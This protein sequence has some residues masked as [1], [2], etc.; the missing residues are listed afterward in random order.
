MWVR[1]QHKSKSLK[2]GVLVRALEGTDLFLCI[3]S[4]VLLPDRKKGDL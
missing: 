1:T 4:Y 3:Y 2:T